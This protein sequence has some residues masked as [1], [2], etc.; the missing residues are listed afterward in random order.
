MST[1]RREPRLR[2]SPASQPGRPRLWSRAMS[3]TTLLD[4]PTS[5]IQA[6][7]RYLDGLAGNQRWEEV[8]ALGRDRQ[9]ALYEK[10]AFSPP[11][12][13]EYFVGQA[14][15]RQEVIHDG[16]NTLPLPSP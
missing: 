3:L 13:F 8:S 14:R 4:D 15:P 11:L 9:R 7:G 2:S 6:I 1:T 10:A 12:D 5:D 16:M